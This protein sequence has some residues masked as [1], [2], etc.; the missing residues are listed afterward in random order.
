MDQD[1]VVEA[2][3]ALTLW[4]RGEGDYALSWYYRRITESFT[5]AAD[6]R[7]FALRLIIHYSGDIHQPLHATSGISTE[8][9]K[10]DQGG[11]FEKLPDVCGA[12]NLHAVW[13]SVAYNFCGFPN[14]VSK[15]I[16]FNIPNTFW[17]PLNDSDWE[18][19]TTT[20]DKMSKDY[21]V[22]QNKIYE[23]QFYQWAAESFDISRDHVYPGKYQKRFTKVSSIKNN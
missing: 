21:P 19:L 3:T 10:G 12:A 9:T 18:S 11:N 16:R 5:D 1:D 23:G 6:A 7:S 15:T 17:Q 14:L 13:D 22:D 20:A 8:Y 2:L 4:L